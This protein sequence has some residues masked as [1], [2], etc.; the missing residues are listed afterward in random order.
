MPRQVDRTTPKSPHDGQIFNCLWHGPSGPH[1]MA[2][3]LLEADDVRLSACPQKNISRFTS[4]FPEPPRRRTRWSART[5]MPRKRKPESTSDS[6]PH[7]RSGMALVS[8]YGSCAGNLQVSEGINSLGR[9][10]AGV[11]G[12]A[13]SRNAHEG[14]GCAYGAS[15]E[16]GR[17]LR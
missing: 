3:H 16:R 8:S 14:R 7:L 13:Y 6:I 4:I 15:N 17:P 1:P 2:H 12:P 9:F 11:H 5:T 10:A